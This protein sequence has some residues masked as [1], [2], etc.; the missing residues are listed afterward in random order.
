MKM[1]KIMECVENGNYKQM[2]LKEWEMECDIEKWEKEIKE[3]E[4]Q[5]E[6]FENLM[7]SAIDKKSIQ[8]SIDFF[9]NMIR[10]HKLL[11]DCNKFLIKIA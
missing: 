6:G 3:Y 8:E 1:E 9:K 7:K 5:I 11:I 4:K 2:T 10:S